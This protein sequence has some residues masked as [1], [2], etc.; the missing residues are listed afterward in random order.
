MSEMVDRF[1]LGASSLVM[2][3]ASND[4]YL[5]QFVKGRGIPCVGVEPTG[6]TAQAARDKGID[7]VEEFSGRSLAS[8]LAER[9]AAPI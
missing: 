6:R 9:G 3:I 1:G 2:E 8:K 5:L 4:G 7:V